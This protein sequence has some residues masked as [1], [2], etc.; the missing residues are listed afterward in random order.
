M[1]G[2]LVPSSIKC[3]NIKKCPISC[4]WYGICSFSLTSFQPHNQKIFSSLSCRCQK[5]F[6]VCATC[7]VLNLSSCWSCVTSLPFASVTNMTYDVLPLHQWNMHS[8]FAWLIDRS[9]CAVT[10]MN[11]KLCA[12]LS[13]TTTQISIS[14]LTSACNFPRV[15]SFMSV[16]YVSG[17]LTLFPSKITFTTVSVVPAHLCCPVNWEIVGE[18]KADVARYDKFSAKTINP[19]H[20][21]VNEVIL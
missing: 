21:S 4:C 11:R 12:R 2:Y 10:F 3:C 15:C 13:P 5:S 9:M 19:S 20:T 16:Q 1:I 8:T 6:S 7:T 17:S 14:S 18:A